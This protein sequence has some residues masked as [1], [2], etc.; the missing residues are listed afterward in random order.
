MLL[1]NIV[2][3]VNNR[4]E[5]KAK[6]D[7]LKNISGFFNPAQ[8]TAVMGP[9]G[10][11]K[12]TLLDLLAGRKNQGALAH[13]FFAGSTCAA[14]AIDTAADLVISTLLCCLAGRREHKTSISAAHHQERRPALPCYCRCD[15]VVSA[16]VSYKDKCASL[17]GSPV[18]RSSAASQ[19]TAVPYS[20]DTFLKS[21]G[22]AHAARDMPL[23][24]F[25]TRPALSI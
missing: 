25:Q 7:I 20:L 18:K 1:Q 2:Y 9:S 24:W 14:L 23:H 21:D 8:M 3:T 5:K 11:G 4:A 19:V 15:L 10:S 6:L 16:Q 22:A 12:S 13:L 17:G